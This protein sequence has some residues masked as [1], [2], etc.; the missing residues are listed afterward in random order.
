MQQ[1]KRKTFQIMQ[2][3]LISDLKLEQKQIETLTH[4][5]LA[6]VLCKV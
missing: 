3:M 5:Q 1:V 4:F 6:F 2:I